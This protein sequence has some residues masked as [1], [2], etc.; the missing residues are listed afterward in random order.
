MQYRQLETTLQDKVLKK[1]RES[2]PSWWVKLN[3]KFTKGLPDIVGLFGGTF[4]AIELKRKGEKPRKL[5]DYVLSQIQKAGGV[6]RWFDNYGDFI[7]WWRSVCNS[8]DGVQA[9]GNSHYDS[10]HGK[11][12]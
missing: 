5:Q 11:L 3:D 10:I 12:R 7:E 8:N 2:K 4:Y 1:L 9:S 6:V